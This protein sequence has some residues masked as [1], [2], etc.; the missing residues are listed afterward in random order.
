MPERKAAQAARRTR[1]PAAQ[2]AGRGWLLE[3]LDAQT[4][5]DSGIWILVGQA[6]LGKSAWLR[7]LASQD[8]N[9]PL[10]EIRPGLET[11]TPRGFWEALRS[12]LGV[13][14]GSGG[15][16]A[17]MVRDTLPRLAPGAGRRRLVLVDGLD[18]APQLLDSAGLPGLDRLP[19]GVWVVATSRPGPHLGGL[20]G[21][22]SRSFELEAQDPRNL[23]D[24]RLYLEGLLGPRAALVEAV[25]SESGGNFAIARHLAR[26]LLSGELT[27]ETL[28][29]QP[30][31]LEAA[32]AALWD[33]CL[34]RVPQEQ[35]ED[36]GRLACLLCEAGEPL[37]DSSLADFLGLSALR[38][39][40]LLARLAPLLVRRDGGWALFHPRMARFLTRLLGRDLAAV[41]RQVITFFRETYPSWEEMDDRYGWLYLGHHCD[42]LART[43]RRRDF[44]ILHW[45]GEG[46]F[47]RA[48]LA[49]TRSLA[50]VLD[51][52]VRCLRAAAEEGDFPR[53]VGYT[54]RIPRLR[55][56]EAA[57]GLHQ[58]A[59]LGELS[60]A[61]QRARLLRR[62]GSRF[63]GLLLLAWQAL[64]EGPP[65][66]A[67]E[68][69]D[70]ALAL[71]RPLVDEDASTLFLVMLAGL[72]ALDRDKAL[73]LLEKSED[74]GLGAAQAL[75]LGRW[76]WVETSLRLATLEKGAE[77]AARM[78]EGAERSGALRSL[79]GELSALGQG[80]KARRMAPDGP[81]PGRPPDLEALE[82]LLRGLEDA[83]RPE[84]AF[85]QILQAA[86]AVRLEARRTS[87]L[88]S[89]AAALSRLAGRPWLAQ[90]FEQLLQA[91]VQIRSA[92]ERLAAVVSV[93]QA[94]AGLG[95]QEWSPQVLARLYAVAETLEDLPLRCR[96]LAEIALALA[97]LR[98]PRASRERFSEAAAGAFKI[99][100]LETRARV[101]FYIAGCV[102]L[103]EDRPR[104]RDL[105]FCALEAREA[106]APQRID[107][108]TRAALVL[109]VTAN[110]PKE[111]SLELFQ[112]AA[113][114]AREMPDLRLRANMLAALAHG[115]ARL[116]EQDWARRL[117]DQALGAA[118]AME[119]GAPQAVTLAALAGQE[120]TWGD[121]ARAER[122]AREALGAC[123]AAA[124]SSDRAE[125]RLATAEALQVLGDEEGARSCLAAALDDMESMSA[126][127]VATS[128]ALAR[129]ARLNVRGG[130]AERLTRLLEGLRPR[131]L[132]LHHRDRE[133]G[134]LS[135]MRAHLALGQIPAARELLELARGSVARSWGM[136]YLAR[137]LVRQAPDE[138]LAW[139]RRIPLL[140]ERMRVVR[141]CALEV[142]HDTLP[143]HR[144]QVLS[145]LAELTLLAVEDEETADF[146]ASRWVTL[147]QDRRV[148]VEILRKIG[149]PVEEIAAGRRPEA[150]EG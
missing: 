15:T 66:L 59:D 81:P 39:R 54:L 73:A 31:S 111:R 29:G 94:L 45:L 112:H 17:Q 113:Q 118:R 119:P 70:E 37:A 116:G 1:P 36:L 134:L 22:G 56:S 23:E 6:G 57:T 110:V 86:A 127:E 143:S 43:A 25:V 65:G 136:G 13:G 147:T 8:E 82:E 106:P 144:P 2:L 80:R 74:P 98:E 60:L 52:L 76:P 129:A 51:D 14:A 145:T 99:E 68:L 130:E 48:K 58:L 16:L 34:A 125:A 64:E 83:P 121:V 135:L 35:R 12:A 123:Q 84:E 109:A 33:E 79:A 75:R 53:I 71:P 38:T 50:A 3:L 141:E 69:L 120:A 89:V 150:A 90:A 55:A 72:A 146:L 108:E 7:H 32:L 87:A 100:S 124:R 95:R 77:L 42:R 105:A 131:V 67:G 122:V 91:V 26:A 19:R 101:L 132:Q 128:T 18:R 4:V 78:P 137:A 27:P 62:E 114:Q 63:L 21:E 30:G 126:A 88:A 133:E 96:A 104:A 107:A 47:V 142:M 140:E 85:K 149:W 28:E 9:W 115:L 148:I 11:H 49:R 46:P 97:R 5:G 139:L 61:R 117:M 10:V 24:L 93:A 41:H 103:A 102:A 138:A 44:S 20:V 92:D 40:E